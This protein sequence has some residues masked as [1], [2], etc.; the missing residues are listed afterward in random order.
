MGELSTMLYACC[1]KCSKPIVRSRRCDGMELT[2]PKC[3]SALRV[4]VDQHAKVSVELVQKDD[5]RVP[6]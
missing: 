6:A 5:E 1:P 2:C 4:T 3:G